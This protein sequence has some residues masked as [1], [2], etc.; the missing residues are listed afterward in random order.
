LSIGNV[1][2]LILLARFNNFL[3]DIVKEFKSELQICLSFDF[4][5]LLESLFM[6]SVE[7]D[8]SRLKKSVKGLGTDEKV[9]LLSSV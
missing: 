6:T 2:N 1:K 5:Q 9:T 8:A 7:F 3:K 4:K